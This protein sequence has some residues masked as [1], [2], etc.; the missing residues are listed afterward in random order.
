[1]FKK[2]H[3]LPRH[4]PLP[5]GS[6]L[7]ERRYGLEALIFL[8]VTNLEGTPKDILLSSV[9]TIYKLWDI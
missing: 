5:S 1:M 2:N 6:E 3:Q 8:P 4:H 9:K 7:V